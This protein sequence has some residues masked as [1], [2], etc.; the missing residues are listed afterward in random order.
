MVLLIPFP[1]ENEIYVTNK[2]K[3]IQNFRLL[4]GKLSERVERLYYI[5]FKLKLQSN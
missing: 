5:G 2:K 3:K 4:I 1:F